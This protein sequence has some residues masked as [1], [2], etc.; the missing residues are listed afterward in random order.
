MLCV[1]AGHRLCINCFVVCAGRAQVVC[2][3][4]VY[5]QDTGGVLSIVLCVQVAY[6]WCFNVVCTGWTQV[7]C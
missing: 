4:C 6:R 1:Q 7:L 3:Y 5:R 2:Q